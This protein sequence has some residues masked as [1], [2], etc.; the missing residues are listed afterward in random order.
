MIAVKG[1]P[2]RMDFLHRHVSDGYRSYLRATRGSVKQMV[3]ELIDYADKTK[4]EGGTVRLGIRFTEFKGVPHDSLWSSIMTPTCEPARCYSCS[5]VAVKE[6]M[7]F[8][9][10]ILNTNG[11]KYFEN[12]YLDESACEIMYR[13]L[14]NGAGADVERVVSLRAHPCRLHSAGGATPTASGCSGARRSPRP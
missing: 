4:A 6:C 5:G 7:G 3:Q 12:L 11:E 14:A 10:R 9:Q 2:L 13:R 8:L 1:G